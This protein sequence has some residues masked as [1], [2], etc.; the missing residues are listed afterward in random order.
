MYYFST[1]GCSRETSGL[2]CVLAF[3][4]LAFAAAAACRALLLKKS[5][6]LISLKASRDVVG[7]CPMSKVS[8]VRRLK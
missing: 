2:G 5:D 7:G 6:M 8:K 1:H 3:E 4:E